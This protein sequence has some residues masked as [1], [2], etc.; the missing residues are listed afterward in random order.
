MDNNA[1]ISPAQSVRMTLAVDRVI[2]SIST[3]F[4]SN[5]GIQPGAIAY[6]KLYTVPQGPI[7]VWNCRLG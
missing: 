6:W 3:T 7:V 4:S 5:S 1:S 2:K